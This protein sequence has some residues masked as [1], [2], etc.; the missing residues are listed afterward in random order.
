MQVCR[1]D[2]AQHDQVGAGDRGQPDRLLDRAVRRG[3]EIDGQQHSSGWREQAR[4]HVTMVAERTPSPKVHPAGHP[5]A[6]RPD[7]DGERRELVR[8]AFVSDIDRQPVSIEV[9]EALD[10][11]TRAIAG[12]LSVDDVLQVIVDQVRPLVGAR[13]AALGIVDAR[14]VIER[15]ITSGIDDAARAPGSGRCRAG[16][17]FS[18]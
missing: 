16:T 12:L 14:G 13:Y 3:R 18:A 11:A 15:F 6:E 10:A 9:Y 7:P 5:G 4:F 2:D 1:F 8:S 17:A